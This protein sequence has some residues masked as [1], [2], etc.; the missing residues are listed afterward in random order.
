MSSEDNSPK[1]CVPQDVLRP[2][3]VVRIGQGQ[4]PAV[5]RVSGIAMDDQGN[6]FLSDEYNHRVL[7]LSVSGDIL[8]TTG[9]K[10]SD[11]GSFSHP[12]GLAILEDPG[13][14][15]VCD[16]WNHRIVALDLHKPV[17]P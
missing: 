6:I 8:W 14:L 4:D 7:K 3:K 11:E 5:E 13:Y 1:D 15:L 16:S 10:G 2:R 17:T 9:G 12:R